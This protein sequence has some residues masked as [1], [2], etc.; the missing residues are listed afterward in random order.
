[1]RDD[2]PAPDSSTEEYVMFREMCE[3]LTRELRGWTPAQIE[4]MLLDWKGG[5]WRIQVQKWF[6]AGHGNKSGGPNKVGGNTGEFGGLEPPKLPSDPDSKGDDNGGD[7]VGE[8]ITTYHAATEVGMP[9]PPGILKAAG[10]CNVDGLAETVVSAMS[11]LYAF[12]KCVATTRRI[13]H[14]ML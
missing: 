8:I 2:M 5:G 9:L 11:L 1:M 13:S 10:G 12:V 7:V 3:S 6:A 4:Q 14:P